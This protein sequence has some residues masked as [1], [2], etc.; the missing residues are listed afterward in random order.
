MLAKAVA[1]YDKIRK[2]G[3]PEDEIEK[4]LTAIGIFKEN[5]EVNVLG[6]PLDEAKE[7]HDRHFHI[8]QS[9]AGSLAL[10]GLPASEKIHHNIALYH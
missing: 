1:T 7:A 4:N 8:V 2:A 9:R 5:D 3:V 6:R 10:Q